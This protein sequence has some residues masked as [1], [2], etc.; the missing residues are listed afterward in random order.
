M[1]FYL[2]HESVSPFW[3]ILAK[4]ILFVMSTALCLFAVVGNMIEAFPDMIAIINAS[5]VLGVYIQSLVKMFWLYRKRESLSQLLDCVG[6]IYRDKANETE[7]RV[8]VLMKY[9]RYSDRIF[10][11]CFAT[12][13]MGIVFHYV[14]PILVLIINGTYMTSLP[15][16]FPFVDYH[17]LAGFLLNNVVQYVNIFFFAI[18][19]IFVEI[20]FGLFCFHAI[21]LSE[22][23]KIDL[24]E[25]QKLA[26]V[27]NQNR[28][29]S[30]KIRLIIEKQESTWKYIADVAELYKVPCFATAATSVISICASLIIVVCNESTLAFVFFVCLVGQLFITFAY[31]ALLS[32]AVSNNAMIYCTNL[33]LYQSV[34]TT[35]GSLEAIS[36]LSAELE[37]PESLFADVA[38]GSTTDNHSIVLRWTAQHGNI[39]K[40][41]LSRLA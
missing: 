15:F 27:D 19:H 33:L 10:K 13:F 32:Y 3:K 12:Y 34:G 28:K 1:W 25:L 36:V 24:Y 6:E 40:R 35:L 31:G 39:Q 9:L 38:E 18:F 30:E 21:A 16:H 5:Y 26:E 11:V 4:R 2:G 7:A 41:R 20:S 14:I 22:L 17:T 29:I 8:N 37:G 23:L